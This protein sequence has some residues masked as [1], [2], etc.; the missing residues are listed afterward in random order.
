MGP[1]ELP[2]LGASESWSGVAAPFT[3]STAV[4][5]KVEQIFVGTMEKEVPASQREHGTEAKVAWRLLGAACPSAPL[6]RELLDHTGSSQTG[7]R[8]ERSQFFQN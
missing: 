6:L 2:F 4:S 3:R 7:P 1:P 5:L 8:A